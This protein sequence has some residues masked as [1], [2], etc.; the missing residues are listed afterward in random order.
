MMSKFGHIAKGNKYYRRGG[1]G[2]YGF[3]T[4]LDPSPLFFIEI[5]PKSIITTQ[6]G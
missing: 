6:V 1:G 2:G 4:G 3:R 5:H